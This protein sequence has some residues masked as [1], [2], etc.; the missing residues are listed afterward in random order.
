MFDTICHEHLEYYSH[1]VIINL[2]KKN[3][4]ELFDFSLNDINGGSTQYYIKKIK[5]KKYKTNNLKINKLLKKEN[6]LNL[7][8]VETFKKFFNKIKKVKFD[9]ITILKKLKSDNKIIHGYGASTKG[10]VLLQYFGIDNADGETVL[11][12]YDLRVGSQ[13]PYIHW[14]SAYINAYAWNGEKRT[15]I[16]GMAIG[17]EMLLSPNINFEIAYD[18]KDKESLQDEWYA[19]IIYVHPPRTGPTAA[20]G[21]NSEM[22]RS[23]KDMSG[24]LLTKVKRNNKIMVEFS[25]SASI[26]RAD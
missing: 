10:N 26:V 21:I 11:D 18:D 22:W 16:E 19:K 7:N 2:L 14:A 3:N 1:R 6:S 13:I 25:G 20:D 4:L 24:E 5:S 15:D 23:Q 8:K 17:S 12:G 9:L